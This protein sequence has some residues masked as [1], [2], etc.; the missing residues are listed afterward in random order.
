MIELYPTIKN[1]YTCP[2]CD[3]LLALQ[4]FILNGMRNLVEGRCEKCGHRFYR[5]LP[6]GPGLYSPSTVD[7]DTLE[8]Y[9]PHKDEGFSRLLID[10]TRSKIS[11]PVELKI[12]RFRENKEYV[13]LNCLDLCWGDCL[14]KLTNAQYY[15]DNFPELG[16]IILVPKS[17]RYFIPEGVAEI[18][19]VDL[20]FRSLANWY[21]S[22]ED[23][24][25]VEIEKRGR[26]YLSVA[27]P[28]PLPSLWSVDRFVKQ[29]DNDFSDLNKPIIVFSYRGDNNRLWGKTLRSQK[30]N[31]I[32]L[33]QQL[34][35]RYG[36]LS[37]ILIG[38]SGGEDFPEGIID[39]RIDK[40][41]PEI[42]QFYVDLLRVTDC[43]IG[44]HGSNLQYHIGLAQCAIELLPETRY[45]NILQPWTMNPEITDLRE[46]MYRYRVIYG[47]R[48]LSDVKPEKVA[49]VMIRQ[50][51]GWPRFRDFMGPRFQT[52]DPAKPIFDPL[53]VIEA[54][55]QHT[56]KKR[57]YDFERLRRSQ[58]IRK[59]ALS[60]LSMVKS[61]RK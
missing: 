48:D 38:L 20:P 47:N 61:K 10:S 46:N 27:Y 54:H 60:L 19:E 28:H 39:K 4:G 31:I 56:V 55:K 42:E 59:I 23:Q 25:K 3:E 6:A 52:R 18:W 22:L 40:F 14:W 33:Y 29:G 41:S 35:K 9:G 57:V 17:L 13:L 30:K 7:M 16:L 43:V 15:L 32:R 44:V 51:D 5:D 34:L 45:G 53:P 24:L 58:E 11:D 37:F 49:K 12:T 36:K 21:V 50:L 1:I 26:V 8:A 2:I